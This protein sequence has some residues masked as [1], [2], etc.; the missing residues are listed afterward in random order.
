ME[1]GKIENIGFSSKK[2]EKNNQFPC[3]N[4]SASMYIL[5]MV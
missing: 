5:N 3:N 2:M 1:N 4:S